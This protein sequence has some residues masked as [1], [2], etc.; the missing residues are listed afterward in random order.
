MIR[1]IT[2]T[3]TETE[4]EMN[5]L[6]DLIEFLQKIKKDLEDGHWIDVEINGKWRF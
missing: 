5:Y 1:T 4:S 3:T 2:I 6:T